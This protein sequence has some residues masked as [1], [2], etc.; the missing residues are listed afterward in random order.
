MFSHMISGKI[1]SGLGEGAYFVAKYEQLFLQH[2][3]FTPFHGTLNVKVKEVPKLENPIT[4]LPGGSFKPVHC[5]KALLKGNGSQNNV[6]VIRPEATKHPKEI[7]EII[8]PICI[9]EKYGLKDG[10]TVTCSL[11]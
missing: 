6:F 1:E 7:V 5:Y 8:A 2:L 9:K 10:D 3:G 11:E 4:I